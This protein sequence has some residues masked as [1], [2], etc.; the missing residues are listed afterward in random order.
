MNESQALLQSYIQKIL[1]IQEERNYAITEED[2]NKIALDLGL[3]EKDL[4]EIEKS[5]M[6]HWKRG[7]NFAKHNRF[8]DA[9]QELLVA[10]ALKP[11]HPEP[12][13]ELALAFQKKWLISGKVEDK[14]QAEYYAKRCL[15]LAPEHEKTYQLLSEI[16]K[17]TVRIEVPMEED[18]YE[19]LAFIIAGILVVLFLLLFVFLFFV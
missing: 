17:K 10:S 1:S 18:K 6:G 19:K 11:L 2:L 12:Y 9:I 5:F 8:D 4:A 13:Y 16:E 7:S 15:L 3:N 14:E